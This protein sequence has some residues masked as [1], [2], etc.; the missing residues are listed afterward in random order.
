[1]LEGGLY[2][3]WIVIVLMMT[4]LYVVISRDNLVKKII[5]LNI[6]Q[7]SVIMFFI[8]QFVYAFGAS[9]LGTLLALQGAEALKVF[10]QYPSVLI[11]GAGGSGSDVLA[12]G[13][14]GQGRTATVLRYDDSTWSRKAAPLPTRLKLNLPAP[15][16]AWMNQRIAGEST[17]PARRSGASRKSRAWRVGGVSTTMRSKAPS[18]DVQSVREPL[19]SP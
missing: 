14:A 9:N 6:F 3:Y 1:M 11:V 13:G 7:V 4:G 5:G 10:E 8:A 2:P 16:N 19:G 17:S 15:S 12:V 18:S